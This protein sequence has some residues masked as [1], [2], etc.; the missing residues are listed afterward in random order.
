MNKFSLPL[1]ILIGVTGFVIVALSFI[2]IFFIK[3]NSDT[4]HIVSGNDNIQDLT[5][6][7]VDD[8][9]ITRGRG[10]ESARE[11]LEES[12]IVPSDYVK[13][14][15]I[16]RVIDDRGEKNSEY[17]KSMPT[18]HYFF[19]QNINGIPVNGSQMG[20]HVRNENEVYYV[21]GKF[22]TN[23]DVNPSSVSAEDAVAIAMSRAVE[24]VGKNAVL[25]N[26]IVENTIYN[27][28]LIGVSNDDS[29]IPA[30]KVKISADEARIPF[31]KEYFVSLLDG[32][33]LH[34][35]SLVFH[36][37]NRQVYNCNN[38]TS[39]CAL[40]RPEGGPATGN[41]E[42]DSGYDY[43]GDT[44]NFFFNTFQRDS[45]DD[46]GSPLVGNI[47]YYFGSLNAAWSQNNRKMYYASGMAVNDIT[48]HELTHAVT[49]DTAQLEYN[50]QSGAINEGMSDVF[51]WAVDPDDWMLGED[52][53][54]GAMRSLS[55]PPSFS[56]PDKLFSNRY[57]C[58][59]QDAYG[60][61]A[62]SGI[63]NK[64][65]YLMVQG[66]SFN[67]CNISPIG[68]DRALAIFYRSLTR[69]LSANSNYLNLYN[70]LLQSCGDLYGSDR[71][72]CEQVDVAL[73]AV[74]IDQQPANVQFSPVCSGGAPSTPKCVGGSQS[75]VPTATTVPTVTQDNSVSYF[76]SGR[77][78][79]D[80]NNN[81]V[82]DSTD[83]P[84]PN[85]T[86]TLSG[87]ASDIATTI[88]NGTFSFEDLFAGSFSVTYNGTAQNGISLT[89]TVPALNVDFIVSGGG[90]LTPTIIANPSGVPNTPTPT[91]V[92][93]STKAP[94]VTPTPSP[95]YYTCD[96][97]PDCVAGQ[98]N[99]QL[100]PLKCTEK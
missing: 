77:V 45:Y 88:T 70:S 23:L 49:A 72:V 16:A 65:F 61:H 85:Q 67:S 75:D 100:C 30:V 27:G 97:D 73:Q 5:I 50:A 42:I 24:E 55:N 68:K 51:G 35:L 54:A 95:K 26:P 91:V 28:R 21:D 34:E 32:S 87:D 19:Q 2:A 7:Y 79:R 47:N 29:N 48:G 98:K 14:A 66:G 69:Y 82:F 10:E 31:A 41:S 33:V 11:F 63:L 40:A 44:Y 38:T 81:N 53:A 78:Y 84:L 12:G 89:Q 76:I 93:V 83:T 96:Y 22:L 56:Q 8:P 25:N 57:W 64:A 3:K 13:N 80:N 90:S 86:I 17:S 74:E 1:P 62:N 60:V 58:S 18:S 20:I 36:V 59:S 9:Y 4:S 94:T 71:N 6:R 39:Q 43:F 52:S 99:I 46:N 92:V 15:T 37:L